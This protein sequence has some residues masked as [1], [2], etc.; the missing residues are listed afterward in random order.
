MG[1]VETIAWVIPAEAARVSRN[2]SVQVA[3][4]STFSAAIDVAVR[5]S[6]A[7]KPATPKAARTPATGHPVTMPI[8]NP[9]AAGASTVRSHHE[10][11]RLRRL[12]RIGS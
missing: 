6:N 10:Y 4:A 3:I 5:P 9:P 7:G 2:S 8:T 1:A 12:A 11:D